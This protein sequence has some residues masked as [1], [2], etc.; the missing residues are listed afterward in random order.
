M[1]VKPLICIPSPRNIKVV[2]D[3][4]DDLKEYDKL[5]MKFHFK[6]GETYRILRNYFLEHKE[7]THLVILPDDLL[8]PKA[9]FEKLVSDLQKKDYPVLSGI[10]N[11][12]CT[13]FANYII[14]V[15]IDYNHKSGVEYLLQNEIPNAN[16]YLKAGEMKGIRKVA[17]AGFPLTFIRRD[18]VEKIPFVAERRGVDCDFS[19]KLLIEKVDQ[20]VDFDARSLHLKGIEDC[21]DISTLMEFQ[22]EH[23]INAKVNFKKQVESKLIFESEGNSTEIDYTKYK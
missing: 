20:Y 6:E 21:E 11:H 12:N 3:N 19:V 13:K 2:K 5:W 18:I 4:I 7:Y 10:C 14:D 8:V 17:F 9:T 16:H 1:N 15:A 22:F 23:S